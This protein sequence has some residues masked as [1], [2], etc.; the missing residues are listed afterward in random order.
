MDTQWNA[1][2]SNKRQC[3]N[4]LED[5]VDSGLALLEEDGL[6]PEILAF[7]WLQ[8]EGDAN[9]A[10]RTAPYYSYQKALMA[11][12]RQRYAEYAVDGEIPFI[13]TEINNEGFWAASYMINDAKNDIA[14]ESA[15]NYIIDTNYYGM[16]ALYENNDLAHYDSTSMLLLGELYAK[17]LDEIYDFSK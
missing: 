13:D 1:T 4:E 12:L 16:T 10:S 5:K 14:R 7:I 8:G 3:L 11:E 9:P 15:R 6:T 2:D 17:M